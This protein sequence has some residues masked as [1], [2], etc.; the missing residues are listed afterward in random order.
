[1]IPKYVDND[2]HRRRGEGRCSLAGS[3]CKE[4]CR[5]RRRSAECVAAAGW[6]RECGRR[7]EAVFRLLAGDGPVAGGSRVVVERGE[8]RSVPLDGGEVGEIVGRERLALDDRY[9]RRGNK[10]GCAHAPAGRP[11]GTPRSPTALSPLQFQKQLRLQ[12]ARRLIVAEG[13]D[14][15]SAGHRVGYDA[16]SHF[17]REYKRLFGAPPLRHVGQV[18]DAAWESASI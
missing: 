8:V 9:L 7:G 2:P 3:R 10:A 18:R 1:M 13:L 11:A 17:T 14:A 4:C 6:R 5:V 16:A 12:E 15:T